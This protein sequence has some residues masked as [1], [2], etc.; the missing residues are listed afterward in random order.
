MLPDHL[1]DIQIVSA[2]EAQLPGAIVG[3]NLQHSELT[4]EID[5]PTIVAVCQFLKQ[6]QQFVRL[7]DLTAV[8]WYP[9]E[10]RFQ[11]VY[12]LHCL[13][14]NERLRLKCLLDSSRAEVDSVTCVWRSA[15][16]Y[17]REVFDLFGI[18]FRNHPRLQRILMPE[19][20][21][22]NPLRKDYPV[23]GYKYSYAK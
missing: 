6:Q 8:D 19:D 12:H 11:V 14:R 18:V 4:L 5:P 22:G 10:P 13:E 16:W 17:E 2:L 20:W 23:H 9:R 15:D 3:G 1:R 7:S 21:E